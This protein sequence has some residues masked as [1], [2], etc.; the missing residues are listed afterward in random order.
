MRR[1]FGRASPL[2]MRQQARMECAE[3][4]GKPQVEISESFAKLRGE[5]GGRLEFLEPKISKIGARAKA[6]DRG[7]QR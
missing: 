1:E 7:D 5:F 2:M 3:Q 4:L 6:A